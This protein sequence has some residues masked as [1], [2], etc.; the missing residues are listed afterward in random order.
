MLAGYQNLPVDS[1]APSTGSITASSGTASKQAKVEQLINWVRN[2]QDSRHLRFNPPPEFVEDTMEL[3]FAPHPSSPW[4]HCGVFGIGHFL[5]ITPT[6][7]LSQQQQQELGDGTSVYESLQ[8]AIRV[9]PTGPLSPISASDYNNAFGHHWGHRH[10]TTP[11]AHL[12]QIIY[13]HL[14]D[15]HN[16][17]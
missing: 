9:K 12:S 8:S 15:M 13:N 16:V 5:D 17:M 4:W 7:C 6:E 11:I 3:W 10:D 1:A 2:H 14:N